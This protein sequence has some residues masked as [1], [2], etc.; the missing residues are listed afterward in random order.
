MTLPPMAIRARVE[1]VGHAEDELHGG[2]VAG[3]VVGQ[4]GVPA[5]R[6]EDEDAAGGHRGAHLAMG[7]RVIQC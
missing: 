7:G 4:G 6:V 2:A 5:H 1:L 3:R